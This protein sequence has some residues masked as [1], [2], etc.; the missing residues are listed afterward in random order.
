MFWEIL[1]RFSV[2][3]DQGCYVATLVLFFERRQSLL[4]LFDNF[5]PAVDGLDESGVTSI[6]FAC[7][8]TQRII[9]YSYFFDRSY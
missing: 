2:G 7:I 8:F 6:F 4:I 1:S 3:V 5:L 9:F